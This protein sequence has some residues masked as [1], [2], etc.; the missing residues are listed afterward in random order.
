MK[1]L[2]KLVWL[3]ALA[4]ATTLALVACDDLIGANIDPF[5]FDGGM[6]GFEASLPDTA[7]PDGT[8]TTPDATPTADAAHDHPGDG[9]TTTLPDGATV[10]P[11]GAVDPTPKDAGAVKDADNADACVDAAVVNDGMGQLKVVC[12][13]AVNL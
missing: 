9:G 8:T 2:R 10:L 1:T 6:N 7:T 4:G 12:L 11:D 3:S 13:D 5:S